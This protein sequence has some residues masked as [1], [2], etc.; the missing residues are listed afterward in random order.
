[1]LPAFSNPDW[2]CYPFFKT[3]SV[4]E[5]I[6]MSYTFRIRVNRPRTRTLETDLH[7]INIPIK[8]T[9]STLYLR[10]SAGDN[11]IPLKDAE[12]WVLV[13]TGYDSAEDALQ[14]GKSLPRRFHDRTC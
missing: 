13:G 14:A 11:T 3:T 10:A 7:E 4:L 6:D 5:N 1:A 2:L 8:N 9:Y 12:Q